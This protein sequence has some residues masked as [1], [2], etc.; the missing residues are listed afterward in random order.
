MLDSKLNG[1]FVHILTIKWYNDHLFLLLDYS[2][3][4]RRATRK[5]G[6]QKVVRVDAVNRKNAPQEHISMR[7]RAHVKRYVWI[8]CLVRHTIFSNVLVFWCFFTSKWSQCHIKIH[9]IIHFRGTFGREKKNMKNLSLFLG[10]CFMFISLV[11]HQYLFT[12]HFISIDIFLFCFSLSYF[13][14]PILSLDNLY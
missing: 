7:I 11:R 10:R 12:Y 9:E 3:S 14:R 4:F 2:F 6:M 5:Y 1:F 13:F 8:S